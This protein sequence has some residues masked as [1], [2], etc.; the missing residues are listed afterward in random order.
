MAGRA[1]IAILALLAAY[2]LAYPAPID[3]LPYHPPPMRPMTGVLEPND[4]LR[5][6]ERFGVGQIDGPEDVAVDSAGRMIGGTH[7]GKL[8]RVSLTGAIEVFADTGGRPLGL[9][10]DGAGNLIVADAI[11]GLLSVDEAGAVSTLTTAAGGIPLGFTDDVDVA[12]DGTIYFTDATTKFHYG[13]HIFDMLEAQPYGRLLRYHPKTKQ[14]E[15]LLDGLHFANGV[16]LSQ[17]EDFVLVVETYRHRIRRYWLKGEQTGHS[18]IFVH[19]LPGY[20]DGVSSNRRGIFWVAMYTLRNPSAD[21][22]APRPFL[23]KVLSRLPRFMWPKPKAYGLVL[24]LDDDGAIVQSLHDQGGQ[25]V[26]SISSVQEHLGYLY[27]GSLTAPQLAR[28]QIFP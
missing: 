25:Q 8:V 10:W 7:D 14:T 19:N 11:K 6:A 2:L 18:D 28:V 23:K 21:W 5:Q 22:L 12:A 13:D 26:A 1:G 20:P 3:P 24:A 27:L 17:G 4:A 15:L 9:A 16:A